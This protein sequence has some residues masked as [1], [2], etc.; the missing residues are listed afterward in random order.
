M[1][2]GSK[3]VFFDLSG[4]R[5]RDFNRWAGGAAAF[6][7]AVAGCLML[8]MFLR[9]A[10]PKLADPARLTTDLHTGPDVQLETVPAGAPLNPLRNRNVAETAAQVK[11]WGF[12]ETDDLRSINSLKSNAAQIDGLFANW[13]QISKDNGELEEL[14]VTQSAEVR[15]WL[16]SNAKHVGVI[17]VVDSNMPGFQL[18]RLL[19]EKDTRRALIDA[20]VRQ[21]RQ[22]SYAGLAISFPQMPVTSRTSL[23]EFLEVLRDRLHRQNAKLVKILEPLERDAGDLE[24]AHFADYA[25]FAGHNGGNLPDAAGPLAGQGQFEAALDTAARVVGVEKLIVAIG[26]F[27]WDRREDGLSSLTSVQGA[28]NLMARAKSPM[29]FDASTLNPHFGYQDEGGQRHDVWY[30]DGATFFNQSRAAL[31]INPA[32]IALWRLGMEDSGVWASFGRGHLP[33][34]H[35]LAGLRSPEPMADALSNGKGAAFSVADNRQRG[36]RSIDF[37]TGLGLIVSERLEKIPAAHNVESWGA[38]LGNTVALT[39]DDGPDPRYTGAILDILRDKGVPATFFVIGKNA[40]RQPALM[41][42][43]FDEGHDIG[44]HTFSHVNLL[45]RSSAEIELELTATQR[46]LESH[47]GVRT[48]LFRA[49][50]NGDDFEVTPS[51]LDLLEKVSRLG[52]ISVRVTVDPF[53]WAGITSSQIRERILSEI[54]EDPLGRIVLLHDGGGS[55]T[56]TVTALPLII[57]DLRASGY[58]FVTVHELLGLKRQDIM[59]LR[60]SESTGEIVLSRI[61]GAGLTSLSWLSD[62][63]PVIA[64]STAALGMLRLAFIVWFAFEHRRICVRRA[65]LKWRPPKLAILVPGF[66]EEKVI[67]KTIHSLLASRL[68]KFEIIVVDDGSSDDTAGIVRRTFW[69]TRRVRVFKIRNGGKSAALNFALQQTDADVVIALDADTVFGPNAI[70]LLVRHFVDP[71][72]GAVAGKAVVG[73]CVSMMA[74][75]QSLEYVTSQNLDRR[76][77]E[78]F[79]AIGVVPGA[80]GA[81][82]RSALIEAGGFPTDTLAEDADVTI[83]LERRGWTVLYEPDAVALTE[84]PETVRAFLKQRFRWMFGTLQVVYKHRTAMSFAVPTGVGSI[85]LPNIIIFQFAFTLLAPIMDFMLVLTILV[86]FREWLAGGAGSVPDSL[87]QISIYW[88]VFQT[89]DALLAGLAMSLNADRDTWRL[90]PLIFLQR[91]CYR[92]LLYVVAIKTLLAAVRGQLVGWGKLLRTGNVMESGKRPVGTAVAVP[93]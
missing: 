38:P 82:K 48:S 36:S 68:R 41:Q 74:R 46:I 63:I 90:F 39:F 83:A 56:P 13:L 80:I 88:A 17:P 34:E 79:N 59:P 27:A 24:L 62:V 93:V 51:G 18:A 53:D 84:A 23:A 60:T 81:W 91:F 44:N 65:G 9:P 30:L 14:H 61:T 11:R 6:A 10:L 2:V 32:G 75:F 16:Q 72:V 45:G 29:Q 49:P 57:D 76:A 67:C 15:L 54:D 47:L 28:W 58:S 50:Y 69:R 12:L 86:G 85:T 55:R 22:N 43:I 89:V 5:A 40:L 35:A 73:N 87:L 8:S 25:V 21:V 31:A 4:R 71:C 37:D 78:G 33:D 20:L 3:P 64:V 70:E 19:A 26:S 7:A 66:N 52:Y 92:Q 1:S 42:R 77:F